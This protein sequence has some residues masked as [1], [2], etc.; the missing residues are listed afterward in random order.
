M[1]YVIRDRA[2]RIV[3]VIEELVSG[4][5][6]TLPEDSAELREY[7]EERE[8]GTNT[9]RMQLVQSDQGMARLVEDLIDLLIAKHLIQFT[10]LPPAAGAKYLQRQEKRQ[11]L[12]A[13]QSLVPDEK[14]IF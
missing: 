7:Y 6:E 1:P 14:G 5:N 3:Q 9:L 13:I 10:E 4:A 12:G 2:G 11:K 8:P